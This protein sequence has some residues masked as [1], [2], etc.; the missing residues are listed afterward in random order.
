[1]I[2]FLLEAGGVN[3]TSSQQQQQSQHQLQQQSES[4]FSNNREEIAT[5]EEDLDEFD[6][7]PGA[8]ELP[9]L[10]SPRGSICNSNYGS[11]HGSTCSQGSNS[12]TLSWTSLQALRRLAN[13][14]AAGCNSGSSRAGSI[15]LGKVSPL[16]KILSK[17]SLAHTIVEILF[18]KRK[19]ARIM[20]GGHVKYNP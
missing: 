20:V 6:L 9:S 3:I 16:Q 1:M 17:C 14:T 7:Y 12:S 11:R 5:D 8:L 2:F 19:C 13:N 15:Q 18:S 10:R 4:E